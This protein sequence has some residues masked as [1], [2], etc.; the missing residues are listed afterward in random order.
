VVLP[1]H[2]DRVAGAVAA[3]A[4]AAVFV[5]CW[6]AI[7]HWFYGGFQLTDAPVYR[8]YGNDIDHG[9]LPYRDFP[10]EYPPGALP[11]F[12]A[13]IA[14]HGFIH[15]D[16]VFALL[17]EVLGLGCIAFAT[18]AGGRVRSLA[19]IAVSPLLLGS[20]VLSRYDL[21]PTLFVVAALAALVHD[22]H[23]WGW[24][25]IGAAVAAK[26]FALAFVPVALVW[27]FRRRGAREL[28]LSLAAGIVVVLAAVL[29]FVV[30]APHGLWHS[31]SG[32]VSRPLQIESLAAAFLT[33]FS[34]PEVIASH[35]SLNLDGQGAVAAATTVAEAVV[36]VA[37]WVA[38]ARGPMT[39]ERLVRYVTAC[40]CAF[41]ALG[42]VLSPQFLIWLVPLVALVRGRRGLAGCLL[43]AAALITTQVYFPKRYWE[44][45]FHLHL[46]WVVLLRDLI[47]V[48]LLATLSL[49]GRARAR[50]S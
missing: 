3:L 35:G 21:W 15:Y 27:T 14:L 19:F 45:I 12:V 11:V 7:H 33:T 10:V 29:P 24:A 32:Q 16:R 43:L 2:R 25:A 40:V 48:A 20:M 1:V 8:G 23:R 50:S 47:L 42:K 28:L 13:P 46:A 38:F 26:G 30:L 22:R 37:L 9:L 36:I 5:G 49:P 18:L 31:V 4:A 6:I 17:M 39:G 44:Y 34:H 41:V